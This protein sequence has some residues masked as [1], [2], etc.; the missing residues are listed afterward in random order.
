M[1]GRSFELPHF[2]SPQLRPQLCGGVRIAGGSFCPNDSGA[3][4]KNI[5][6]DEASIF[7][8]G[9]A[10][11]S[12]LWTMEGATQCQQSGSAGWGCCIPIDHF[13]PCTGIAT[14]KLN[15]CDVKQVALQSFRAMYFFV[16]ALHVADYS[17]DESFGLTC[18]PCNCRMPSRMCGT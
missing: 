15:V 9:S 3:L 8:S 18:F 4:N 1:V 7:I 17:S 11:C 2:R 5:R 10:N 14:C 12:A 13:F 6:C 16:S